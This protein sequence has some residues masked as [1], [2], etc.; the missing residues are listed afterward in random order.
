MDLWDNVWYYKLRYMYYYMYMYMV[1]VNCNIFFPDNCIR[2]KRFVRP[3]QEALQCDNCDGLQHRT[4]D[5]GTDT[6]FY[7][8]NYILHDISLNNM[9]YFNIL[10][11]CIF[12]TVPPM[13]LY[14]DRDFDLDCDTSVN[15]MTFCD[16][17]IVNIRL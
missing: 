16:I 4:C 17:F 6:F 15:L 9:T 3:R 8:S 13:W 1:F 12:V 14:L 7:T 2:C 10:Y 5:T 11:N